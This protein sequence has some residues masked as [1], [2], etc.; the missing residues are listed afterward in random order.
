MKSAFPLRARV[1]WLLFDNATNPFFV[2]IMIFIFGPYFVSHVASDPIIGQQI[3]GY[4]VAVAGIVVAVSAP[5]L[6]AI[7]DKTGRRKRWIGFFSIMIVGG[8]IPLYFAAPDGHASMRLTLV[9]LGI[10]FVGIRL[11]T[12]FNNGM[13][14]HIVPPAQVGKYSGYGTAIGNTGGLI[15]IIFVLGFMVADPATNKTLFGFNPVFGLDAASY[16]G[17]RATALLATGW[18]CLFVTPLFF[19]LRRIQNQSQA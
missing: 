9:S 17:E 18:Y 10:T 8:L 13:L 12:T 5:I 11:A 19:F 4:T 6:G 3:W 15:L 14:P 1:S 2:L 16:Q 7:A